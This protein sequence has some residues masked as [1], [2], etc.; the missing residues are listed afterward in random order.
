ML[1]L[2]LRKRKIQNVV[3]YGA[4]SAG[5]QLINSLRT[6]RNYKIKFIVDDNKNCGTGILVG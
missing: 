5:A 2:F 1:D 4:G 3:V 6:V